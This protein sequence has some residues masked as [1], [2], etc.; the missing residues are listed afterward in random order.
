MSGLI[1][2]GLQVPP[3]MNPVDFYLQLPAMGPAQI[4]P[5]SD[6]RMT[7]SGPDQVWYQVVA[8][9]CITIPAFFLMLRVYTRVVIF[10]SLELVDYFLFLAFPLIVVEIVMGWYMV[11]W[12]AGVHQW[13]VTLSQLFNQLFWANTAQV[14]YCPLSFL[15]KMHP[16]PVFALVRTKSQ[17]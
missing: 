16:A 1:P 14:I 13:Q 7:T 12:G 4:P 11:R 2:P 8:V 17:C 5:G 9:M 15:V 6:T 10:K 3:R